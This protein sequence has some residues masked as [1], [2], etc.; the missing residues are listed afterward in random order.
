MATH[1]DAYRT[2]SYAAVM[3]TARSPPAHEAIKRKAEEVAVFAGA[4]VHGALPGRDTCERSTGSRSRRATA[5]ARGLGV[6]QLF[7]RQS[8]VKSHVLVAELAR[9]VI[10]FVLASQFFF[11]RDRRPEFAPRT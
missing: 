7:R 9:T 6:H 10:R 3:S 2:A 11:V 1:P 8:E 5:R 4:A